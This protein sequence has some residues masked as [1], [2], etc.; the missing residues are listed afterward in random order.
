MTVFTSL[1]GLKTGMG[2]RGRVCVENNIFWSEIGSGFEE[3]GGT[4]PQ[5]KFP[6]I[7]PGDVEKVLMTAK[8]DG[9]G[10]VW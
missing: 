4:T 2:L 8:N 1:P 6:G 5:Q 10:D 7:P 3:L 9:I